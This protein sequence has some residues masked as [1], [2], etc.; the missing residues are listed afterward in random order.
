MTIP[1][2]LVK[3]AFD[4]IPSRLGPGEGSYKLWAQASSASREDG[5][6]FQIYSFCKGYESADI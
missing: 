4:V 2:L 3:H 1:G 5:A 6:F